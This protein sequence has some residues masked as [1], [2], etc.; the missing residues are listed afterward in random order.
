MDKRWICIFCL[1]LM[2][3]TG[4]ACARTPE[5]AGPEKGKNPPVQ[6]P[7]RPRKVEGPVELVWDWQAPGEKPS[8]LAR[9]KKLPGITVLSPSWFVIRDTDGHIEEKNASLDY[10]PQAHAKGYRVWALITNGFDPDLTHGLLDNPAGRKNAAEGLLALARKY[11]LDGINLDFENIRAEDSDRLTAFVGEI[12][13]PLRQEGYTVSIDVTVPSD[14]GNWSRCYDRKA[15]SGQV[16]YVMLMAYDEHHRLSKVAGS[17]ASLPWVERGIRKT[18]EEVPAEKLVLGM[19]LYMRDWK[20]ENGNVSAKT[21][22]MPGA[23][24]LIAEKGLVPAWRSE[25]AQYYFEYREQ[26]VLHRVWQEDARSL[27]LKNALISRYN[28]AGSAYWRKGLED[29]EVWE[30][31]ADANFLLHKNK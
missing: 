31:L 24:K 2:T 14:N 7:Y 10:A 25:E 9:E 18:L 4:T 12:A 28:L 8:T 1:C 13:G 3:L 11:Q 19:P 22:S 30:I 17:V 26:G 6:E 29:Q 5:P 20:E 15:L 21:L 16:D 27:A 23:R